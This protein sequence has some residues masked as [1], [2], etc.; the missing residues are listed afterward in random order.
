MPQCGSKKKN[1]IKQKNESCY[2]KKKKI[3]D[4]SEVSQTE[5]DKCGILKNNTRKFLC[6][7]AG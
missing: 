3:L 7:V 5:K 4:L 2:L 6:G 1:K